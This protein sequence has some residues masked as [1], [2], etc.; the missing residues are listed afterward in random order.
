MA[1]S[2][3]T[4]NEQVLVIIV[5]VGLPSELHHCAPEHFLAV[6]SGATVYCLWDATCT[7]HLKEQNFPIGG[8]D[9][10]SRA[11][12]IAIG[13]LC[14]VTF[15]KTKSN[16][17][18]KVLITLGNHDAWVIL[19]S[20]RML[21]S[22]IRAK[23]Q[24]HRCI[25]EGPNPGLIIGDSG[26]CVCSELVEGEIC[27]GFANILAKELEPLWIAVLLLRVPE[28]FGRYISLHSARPA[29]D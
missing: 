7:V 28:A 25:L 5:P 8:I 15:C 29:C 14:G 4:N 18:S 3:S 20:S 27:G 23:I 22:Q 24:G 9:I 21:F 2:S 6:D 19:T 17:W 16:N 11:V 1:D 10:D 13:H 26:E 12:C